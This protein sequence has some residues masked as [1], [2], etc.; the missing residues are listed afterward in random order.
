MDLAAVSPIQLGWSLAW[1]GVIVWFVWR[2]RR[3][4]P[5]PNGVMAAYATLIGA[6]V[7]ITAYVLT[8]LAAVAVVVGLVAGA[9]AYVVL[10]RP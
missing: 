10:R 7:A 4:G 9:I 6:S 3:L 5:M 1:F 2:R 8:S